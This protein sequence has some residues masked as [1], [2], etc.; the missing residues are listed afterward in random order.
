MFV[1]PS[2]SLTRSIVWVKYGHALFA[3][4]A[5]RIDEFATGVPRL[6]PA[7]RKG[8]KVPEV[9]AVSGRRAVVI[10]RAARVGG[11]VTESAHS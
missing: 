1:P 10:R 11:E 3:M 5:R 6:P 4:T 9:D 8:A 2:T 7:L